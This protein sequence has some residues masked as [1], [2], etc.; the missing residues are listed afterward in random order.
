MGFAL[1][2]LLQQLLEF[3]K[4]KLNLLFLYVIACELRQAGREGGR[5]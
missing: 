5:E 2:L 4:W 3:G 1:L